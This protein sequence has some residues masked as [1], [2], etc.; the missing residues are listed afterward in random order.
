VVI[1][2]RDVDNQQGNFV[3][4]DPDDGCNLTVKA[5]PVFWLV[6]AGGMLQAGPAVPP[7]APVPPTGV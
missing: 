2:Q 7:A 3:Y 1:L 4:D 6:P 5:L